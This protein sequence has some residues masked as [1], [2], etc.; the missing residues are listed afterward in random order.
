M[1]IIIKGKEIEEHTSSSLSLEKYPFVSRDASLSSLFFRQKLIVQ[2]HKGFAVRICSS[3]RIKSG[4]L[5]HY[6]RKANVALESTSFIEGMC[7]LTQ[8]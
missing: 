8:W 2:P 7:L 3:E 1:K 5:G 4:L 6:R